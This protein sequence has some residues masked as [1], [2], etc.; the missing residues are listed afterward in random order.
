MAKAAPKTGDQKPTA[1]V[2][3]VVK[4]NL[5]HDN[6]DYVDGDPIELDDTQAAPLL[7]VGAI[8]LKAE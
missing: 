7:E 3:Y 1:D 2:Q 5:S 6:V 8:A 4:T